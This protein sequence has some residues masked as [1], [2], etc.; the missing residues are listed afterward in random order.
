DLIAVARY[1]DGGIGN[2]LAFLAALGFDAAYPELDLESYLNDR[3]R[4]LMEDGRDTCL[5]SVD[6]IATLAGTAFT[7]ISDFT[8]TNPLETEA[9][10]RRLNA[11]KLGSDAPAVPVFMGHA[12]LDELIPI[13]QARQLRSDWCSQGANVTWKTYLLV[14]H[15]LGMLWT[16]PDAFRFLNDRFAGRQTRGNC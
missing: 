6:G 9:W 1:L 14:E 2:G 3:G 4:Q 7:R 13:A 12:Q 10:Q 5:V 8:T 15:A 16:Q 11:N